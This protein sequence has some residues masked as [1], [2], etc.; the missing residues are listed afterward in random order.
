M[1]LA[2]LEKLLYSQADR[3]ASRRLPSGDRAVRC[4][5]RAERSRSVLTQHQALRTSSAMNLNIALLTLMK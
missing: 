5:C 4:C 2:G 1:Q 3:S